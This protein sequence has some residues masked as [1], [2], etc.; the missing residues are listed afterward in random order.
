VNVPAQTQTTEIAGRRLAW[1]S[2]GD[3]PLLLLLNGYAATALDWDPVA[4]STLAQSFE[5]ICPDNRGVG[6]SSFGDSAEPLTIDGMAADVEALLDVL[7][8]EAVPVAGWSMGGFIAQRLAMRAPERVTALTLLSTDPG[9]PES[10][11]A[12]PAVWARLTDHSGTPREQATRLIAL[13]FPP[14]LAP[15][16]DEQF[17]EVV[18]TARAQLSPATLEA[19]EAAMAAWHKESQPTPN[20]SL[21]VLV[22]HGSEDV[23]IP[24]ENVDA[25]AARWPGCKV[26][27][28]AGSGHA[29]IAQEPKR[30]AALVAS[31]LDA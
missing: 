18:A 27:R 10:V 23:V 25:L 7:E 22:A 17:G 15:G 9:G 2:V 29:F 19:Q 28:F 5:L 14:D 16:I 30:L 3:G 6:E 4:L 1:R 31:F 8:V 12:D 13:L 11:Q 20:D 26:E 21:P 24:P